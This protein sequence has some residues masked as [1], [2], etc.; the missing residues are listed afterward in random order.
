MFKLTIVVLSLFLGISLGDENVKFIYYSGAG[1]PTVQLQTVDISTVDINAGKNVK[2]IIH[3]AFTDS[4]ADWYSPMINAYLGKGYQ[5]IA[6][7]WGKYA[8]NLLQFVSKS[9]HVGNLVGEM[10]ANLQSTKGI[11][12]NKVHIIGHSM[13]AHV[14]G[15]AGRKVISTTN[16]RIARITSLDGA[17][18]SILIGKTPLSSSDADFVD[19]IHTSYKD[20]FGSVSFFVNGAEDQPGCS[21][22]SIDCSHNRAPPYFTETINSNGF[23]ATQCGS[24]SSFTSGSCNGNEQVVMG[25]NV[26]SSASG[27]FYLRTNSQPPYA[28]G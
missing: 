28:M 13:G 2:V 8:K 24:W 3:G 20:K 4:N 19:C 27:D 22:L 1:A 21:S 12:F 9:D 14:A 25:E 26:P 10:I 18:T 15:Y 17:G 11:N 5:V 16:S 23:V 6:I 7:D